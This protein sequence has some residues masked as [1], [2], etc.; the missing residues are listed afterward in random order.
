MKHLVNSYPKDV[1]I[2]H[3]YARELVV[4]RVS[5]DGFVDGL[6]MFDG[7]MDKLVREPT[8]AW[9]Q[10]A[11]FVIGRKVAVSVQVAKVKILDGR[12]A[13]FA[14]DA[15]GDLLDRQGEVVH[16]ADDRDRR[17][18]RLG[19]TIEFLAEATR[20]RLFFVIEQEDLMD[21]RNF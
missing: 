17:A 2:D 15:H 20:L 21:D 7:A 1:A 11:K 3:G 19:P 16:R 14:S 13:A 4:L 8:G 5:A 9:T 12:F 6:L 10:T 18:C